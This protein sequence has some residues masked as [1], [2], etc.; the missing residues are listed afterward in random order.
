MTLSSYRP[1]SYSSTRPNWGSRRQLLIVY[2]GKSS[3]LT[4][5]HL[6]FVENI[7]FSTKSYAVPETGGADAIPGQLLGRAESLEQLGII[8]RALCYCTAAS[9]RALHGIEEV[10]EL[11]PPGRDLK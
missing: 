10:V 9:L 1:L 2:S 5:N 7:S 8:L 11:R 6:F 3:A 4:E